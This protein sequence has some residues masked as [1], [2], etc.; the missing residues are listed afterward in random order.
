M[1]ERS[2]HPL[3][4]LSVLQ[5][6]KWW[7]IYPVVGCLVLGALVALLM[8]REYQSK[9]SIAVAAP[10]LSPDLLKG[11]SSL[12]ATERQRAISQHLLSPAVLERVV[13][14]EQLNGKKSTEEMVPWLHRRIDVKVPN[15]IGTTTRI[16]PDRGIDSFDVIV[17]DSVPERT[18]RI[19]NRLADVFV[20]ENSRRTTQRAENTVE[21]LGQQLRAS[22]ER[23]NQIEEQLRQ[24]KERFNGRLP[25]QVDANLQTANGLRNQLESVSTQLSMESNQLLLLETQIEQMRQGTGTAHLTSSAAAAIHTAQNRINE[26]N[27]QLQAARALGYTDKHPEVVHL[28][29]EIAQSRADLTS[30]KQDGPAGKA[31]LSADPVYSQKVAERDALKARIQSLRRAETSIR[32]EIGNYQR[33]VEAAPMVE[34]EMSGLLREQETETARLKDLRLKHDSAMLQGDI[35]RQEGGE[36]FS[37]L[38]RASVPVQVSAEPLKVML[39]SLGL[40]LM[41]GAVLL[42]GRE[43]LDRSVH[44]ARALQSEFE[45]PVLGEIPTIHRAA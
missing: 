7:F 15:P 18:Q 14:E 31:A 45:L 13:R 3:D 25:S 43:F 1:E 19:T 37:I 28:K 21:V 41:L 11:V 10:R 32:G 2:F 17:T 35:A 5:R 38:Y 12:D 29:A 24:K 30:A 27:Q 40:G 8:P 34:Q 9:A 26:L 36:R 23:L 22:Q 4:Y 20:Q 33:K 44:D 39:I 6:R 16:A 42:V